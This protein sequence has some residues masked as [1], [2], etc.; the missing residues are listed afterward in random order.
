MTHVTLF[1]RMAALLAVAAVALLV[2]AGIALA[3]TGSH[4]ATHFYRASATHSAK[5][6]DCA[7]KPG[8]P[9]PSSSTAGLGE[10][11][12]PP[13]GAAGAERCSASPGAPDA[14]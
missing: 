7:G 10:R 14:K 11:V 8:G 12:T 13:P 4:S 5:A 6:S 2:T 3:R 9:P 1:R